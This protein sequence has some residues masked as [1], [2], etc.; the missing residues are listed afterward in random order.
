MNMPLSYISSHRVLGQIFEDF[1]EHLLGDALAA[2]VRR[3]A[4]VSVWN[5]DHLS[6]EYVT[7][8]SPSKEHATSFNIIAS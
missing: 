4:R 3:A 7:I 2:S 8:N 6:H 5:F 1:F